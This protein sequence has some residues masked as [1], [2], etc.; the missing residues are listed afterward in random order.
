M[1][2]KAG[3]AQSPD[4]LPAAGGQAPEARKWQA[5]PDAADGRLARTVHGRTA[6]SWIARSGAPLMAPTADGMRW[7]V[8]AGSQLP[9]WVPFERPGVWRYRYGGAGESLPGQGDPGERSHRELPRLSG[10]HD[11]H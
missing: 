2:V 5:W 8:A 1:S 7:R 6:R 3:Q 11:G 10:G 9:P 4:L